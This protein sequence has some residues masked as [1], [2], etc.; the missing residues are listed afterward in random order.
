MCADTDWALITADRAHLP[1]VDDTKS[2]FK[3]GPR[4]AGAGCRAARVSPSGPP[5]C[6]GSC[7]PVQGLRVCGDH[8]W[9][10]GTDNRSKRAVQIRVR[11]YLPAESTGIIQLGGEPWVEADFFEMTRF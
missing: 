9:L 1:P 3:A 6:A 2:A 5:P 4:A 11:G 7:E 10:R 8:L